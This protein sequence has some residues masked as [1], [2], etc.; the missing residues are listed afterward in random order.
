MSDCE[1]VDSSDIPFSADD[2]PL[3]IDYNKPIVKRKRPTPPPKQ[4]DPE[5]AYWS[6]YLQEGAKRFN[7][8]VA[9]FE[10]MFEG[11]SI[12][13][14]LT[15]YP[16]ST[17]T[18][19]ISDEIY[20]LY[21]N[22]I[23]LLLVSWIREE[24]I[25]NRLFD[26]NNWKPFRDHITL[27]HMFMGYRYLFQFDKYYLQLIIN[28]ECGDFDKCNYCKNIYYDNIIN[29]G[30]LYDYFFKFLQDNVIPETYWRIKT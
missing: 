25:K 27:S 20:D 12:V 23:Q 17:M 21:E 9:H 8:M 2:E 4:P 16:S 26:S 29:F 6:G 3:V 11:N 30:L 19:S 5:P 13:K 14:H 1:S 15:I 22:E 18:W 10:D 24:K 28:D 7:Y